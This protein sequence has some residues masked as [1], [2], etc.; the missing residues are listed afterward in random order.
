MHLQN[1]PLNDCDKAG[2]KRA[3]SL[4]APVLQLQKLSNS[5]GCPLNVSQRN[6]D[7]AHWGNHLQKID[8]SLLKKQSQRQQIG[9]S[10][11]T[12]PG[13]AVV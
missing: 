12:G 2:L 3:Y 9:W 5:T 10:G 1:G 8:M 6:P 4:Q 13:D 11:S 7:Q